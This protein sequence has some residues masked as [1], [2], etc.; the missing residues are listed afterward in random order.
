[1][2]SNM[3]VSNSLSI[4]YIVKNLSNTNIRFIPVSSTW[5][6]ILIS[7]PLM[8][9]RL[10]VI[11]IW[12]VYENKFGCTRTFLLFLLQQCWENITSTSPST[13]VNVTHLRVNPAN[14]EVGSL[15]NRWYL[16]NNRDIKSGT[17]ID[18]KID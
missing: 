1:M 11:D 18:C 6:L 2:I 17:E 16:R 9:F 12:K 15:A 4:L 10:I 5:P 3:D 7:D 13:I 14:D 8:T